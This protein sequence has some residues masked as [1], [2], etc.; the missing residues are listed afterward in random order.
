MT[1]GLWYAVVVML[2]V[3]VGMPGFWT[4]AVATRSVPEIAAGRRDIW[5]HIAAEALTGAALVVAA[6]MTV[7]APGGDG[8]MIASAAAFGSLAYTAIQSPGYY[9]ESRDPAMLTMF[10]GVWLVTI[11]AAVLRFV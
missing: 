10:C 8:P 3:G 2:V 4:V 9:V 6:A 5:F 1:P 7:A 11:P